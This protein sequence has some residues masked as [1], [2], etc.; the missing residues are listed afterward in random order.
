MTGWERFESDVA[1]MWRALFAPQPLIRLEVIRILVPLA[2]LGFLSSRLIHA[3]DWLS[4]AGFRLPD[5]PEDWRQP[6]RVPA[7]DPWAAWLL[8]ATLVVTGL[9]V[10]A[11]LFTRYTSAVFCVG[12]VYVALA[13]RL[14]AFTVSKIGPIL[15][16]AICLSPAGTRWS[17]DERLRRNRDSTWIPPDRVSGGSIVFFQAMLPIFYLSSGIAKANGD[18]MT[19]PYVLWT[20]LHDSYQTPV[21]WFLANHTPPWGFTV[22]QTITLVFEFF[23]PAW[24]AFRATRPFALAWALAMHLMIGLM[25]GP[26]IWFALLMMSLLIGSYAPLRWLNWAFRQPTS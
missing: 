12:L 7:L 9:S 13:D 1:G 11:G 10:S 3:D 20:H 22:L 4:S 14:A 24:F 23:A 18:W 8:C 16:L 19:Y 25:F 17:I 6:I 26:V 5:I 2:I 21:S 15:I